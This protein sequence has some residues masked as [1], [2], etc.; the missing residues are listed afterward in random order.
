MQRDTRLPGAAMAPH[1]GCKTARAFR[2]FYVALCKPACNKAGAA[3]F[4]TGEKHF[5]Q[6]LVLCSSNQRQL[7]RSGAS[8]FAAA[9][10]MQLLVMLLL[11]VPLFALLWFVMSSFG[12]REA[13][14]NSKLKRDDDDP[15]LVAAAAVHKQTSQYA[16]LRKRG[17]TSAA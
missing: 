3:R 7:S 15:A 5:C 13:I 17:G 6:R 8:S 1:P 11:V 14:A 12:E 9:R 4:S 2:G 10:P 16:V